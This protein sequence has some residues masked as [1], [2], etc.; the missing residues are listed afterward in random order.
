MDTLALHDPHPMATSE[1]PSL[2]PDPLPGLQF[3]LV[4]RFEALS[5]SNFSFFFLLLY[6][7]SIFSVW[8]NLL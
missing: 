1:D 8:T 3:P 4:A 2:H 6:L 5:L 7:P